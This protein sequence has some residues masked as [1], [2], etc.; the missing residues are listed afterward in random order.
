MK[1]LVLVSI[2]AAL[3]ASSAKGNM[4]APVLSCTVTAAQGDFRSPNPP[5]VGDVLP[6]DLEAYSIGEGGSGIFLKRSD[7]SKSVIPFYPLGKTDAQPGEAARYG[8]SAWRR[9]AHVFETFSVSK[10]FTVANLIQKWDTFDRS[11]VSTL[12]FQ[13]EAH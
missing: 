11:A 7:G 13:C 1:A 12:K 6:V 4:F 10:S 3:A 2:A 9:D 5:Q 8:I